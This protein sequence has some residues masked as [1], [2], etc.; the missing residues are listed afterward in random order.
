MGRPTMRLL[1]HLLFA[2]AILVGCCAVL[3]Y[4]FLTSMACGYAPNSSGCRGLPWEL[5]SDD[6]FWLVVLPGGV[7][8]TLLAL[9]WLARG[10]ARQRRD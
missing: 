10:K 2:A 6:R 1:S 3:I 7:V 4:G 9:G 5:N 8:V